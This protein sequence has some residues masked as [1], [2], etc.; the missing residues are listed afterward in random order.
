MSKSDIA[1]EIAKKQ[2]ISKAK[3]LATVNQTID[4]I[5]TSLKKGKKVSLIGFG[6][7]LIRK[8]K[9]RT[10]R[11]PQTGKSIKIAASKA[12]AFKAGAS[13]KKLVNK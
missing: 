7:F 2:G 3:A 6:T 12:P 1:A 4:L 13:L 8:R 9:A 5:S 10:G 11:N